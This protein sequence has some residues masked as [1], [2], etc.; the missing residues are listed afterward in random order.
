M[1]SK[2]FDRFSAMVSVKMDEVGG[3]IMGG[4]RNTGLIIAAAACAIL[5]LEISHL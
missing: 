3:Q 1:F 5:P 4:Q 2:T